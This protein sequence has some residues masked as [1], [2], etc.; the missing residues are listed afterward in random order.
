MEAEEIF[1]LIKKEILKGSLQQR[2]GYDLYD[3][4]LNHDY[5]HLPSASK[6]SLKLFIE[7]NGEILIINKT[8]NK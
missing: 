5:K 2:L 6:A 8:E 4:I 3:K 1:T 7:N